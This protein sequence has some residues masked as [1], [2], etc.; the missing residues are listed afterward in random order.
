DNLSVGATWV[1]T[2]SAG[3]WSQQGAKLVG[4]GAV[5]NANQGIS[6]AMSADGDTAVVGGS[7]DNSHAG[8]VWMYTRSAGVWSQQGAKLVG[9]GAVGAANQGT[10]VAMSADGSPP[11]VGGSGDDNGVGATWVYARS[12]GVWSQQGAKL[13]STD[14]AGHASQ[15]IS[16][17]L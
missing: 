5:G 12:G 16:V 2:R 10:S 11:V 13:V 7:A 9:T 14:A 15:G 1:F 8:A 17:A 6:L 3:V 4:T